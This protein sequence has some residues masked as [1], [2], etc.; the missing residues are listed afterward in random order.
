MSLLALVLILGYVAIYGIHSTGQDEGLAARL[1]Q[2]TIILQIF[3]IGYF[4]A[5]YFT[6]QPRETLLILC[7]QLIAVIMPIGLILYLESL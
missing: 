1:F 5:R 2:L 4:V 6:K 3:V 7:V